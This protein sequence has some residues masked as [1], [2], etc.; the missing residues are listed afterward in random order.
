MKYQKQKN[1]ERNPLYYLYVVVI[2]HP[3]YTVCPLSLH[4]LSTYRTGIYKLMPV[5]GKRLNTSSSFADGVKVHGEP[6]SRL[7]AH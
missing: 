3:V 2:R 1:R 4:V 7:S 6:A 5:Q